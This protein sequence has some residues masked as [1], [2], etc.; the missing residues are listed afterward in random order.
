MEEHIINM[1]E[2]NTLAMKLLHYFITEKGYTPIVLQGAEDEIWLEN[3]DEDYKVV[4]LAPRFLPAGIP[5]VKSSP[6]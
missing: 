2:K 5:R 4:R 3:L 6:V 1:D